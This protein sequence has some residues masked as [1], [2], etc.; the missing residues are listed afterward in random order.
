M[1]VGM[2]HGLVR[3]DSSTAIQPW[4]FSH[5]SGRECI[6]GNSSLSHFFAPAPTGGTGVGEEFA[7]TRPGCAKILAKLSKP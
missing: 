6:V 3:S 4:Q 2:N 7:V 1:R 5:L